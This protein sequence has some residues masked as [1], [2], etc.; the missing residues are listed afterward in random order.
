MQINPPSIGVL[1][2]IIVLVV[3]VVLAII[4]HLPLVMAVLLGM[5][6]LARLF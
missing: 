5:L 3:V 2:A 1:L 4:G 6:A